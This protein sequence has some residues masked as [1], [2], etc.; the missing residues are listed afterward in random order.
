MNTDLSYKGC[1]DDCNLRT[2]RSSPERQFLMH[3]QMTEAKSPFSIATNAIAL[4]FGPYPMAQ[5]DVARVKEAVDAIE[6][7]PSGAIARRRSIFRRFCE[8]V[9]YP[10]WGV[11]SAC[12]E[13]M[14]SVANGGR[15]VS[16]VSGVSEVVPVIANAAIENA[17]AYGFQLTTRPWWEIWSTDSAI[18]LTHNGS[19]YPWFSEPSPCRANMPCQLR[20]YLVFDELLG[21]DGAG[22]S[23]APV[24]SAFLSMIPAYI[25]AGACLKNGEGEPDGELTSELAL[26][27]KDRVDLW[28]W[29]SHAVATYRSKG[30]NTY[31]INTGDQCVRHGLPPQLPKTHYMMVYGILKFAEVSDA[32]YA[33][34][35]ETAAKSTHFTT[36][37]EFYAGVLPSLLFNSTETAE[38][39]LE[40]LVDIA[41][42]NGLVDLPN[43]TGIPYYA[44]NIGDCTFKASLLAMFAAYIDRLDPYLTKVEVV[45]AQWMEWV[46]QISMYEASSYMRDLAPVELDEITAITQHAHNCSGFIDALYASCS[47]KA[48][49][50]TDHLKPHRDMFWDQVRRARDAYATRFE[51]D[52]GYSDRVARELRTVCEPLRPGVLSSVRILRN[53]STFAAKA[54][55]D[56]K[57]AFD[58][59][60]VERKETYTLSELQT[61]LE[62]VK[63]NAPFVAGHDYDAAV[64]SKAR[65]NRPRA[66]SRMSARNILAVQFTYMAY[67]FCRGTLCGQ[68]APEPRCPESLQKFLVVYE[69][70]VQLIG[71]GTFEGWNDRPDRGNARNGELAMACLFMAFAHY[72]GKSKRVT[73]APSSVD[74][75]TGNGAGSDDDDDTYDFTNSDY[76]EDANTG[77][78]LDRVLERDGAV[79]GRRHHR[80]MDHVCYV[81]V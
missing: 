7:T 8:D 77:C 42:E 27:L 12:S 37:S 26:E 79:H 63:E 57:F 11:S 53:V 67:K 15:V 62:R 50:G 30:G 47:D 52:T 46:N 76:E 45:T 34:F 21:N 80:Q 43:V 39:G 13:N 60:M 33:T 51:A 28:S 66:G 48:Y 44:Q 74:S 4:G 24:R 6:G 71:Y 68:I 78:G 41:G 35:K 81:E 64:S 72:T 25:E 58:A 38:V 36:G 59:S 49:T 18:P 10:L 32:V 2:R 31:F 40:R 5:A 54:G 61:F 3:M 9:A 19:E 23:P 17:R 20:N 22:G 70:W 75:D 14:L 69:S 73:P 16:G 29:M 65:A 56:Q 55:A 1:G